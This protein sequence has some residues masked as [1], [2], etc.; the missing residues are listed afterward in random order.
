[1]RK[2]HVMLYDFHYLGINVHIAYN[3]HFG[4]LGGHGGLK[5]ASLFKFDLK[6]EISNFNNPGII[7]HVA[8]FIFFGGL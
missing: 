1:M 4:G 7:V 2:R 5:M 8:F 6:F 3:S